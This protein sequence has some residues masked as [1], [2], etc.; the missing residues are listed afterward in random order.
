MCTDAPK[1]ACRTHPCTA[2]DSPKYAA[3][4]DIRHRT[5]A[6]SCASGGR[7][8]FRLSESPAN[9]P[10]QPTRRILETLTIDYISDLACSSRSQPS[11]RGPNVLGKQ[12]FSSSRCVREWVGW[13][14]A[15]N[16]GRQIVLEQFLTDHEL[17]FSGYYDALWCCTSHLSRDRGC[18]YHNST[19]AGKPC[20]RCLITP[21]RLQRLSFP[22]SSVFALLSRWSVRDVALCS[23][24]WQHASEKYIRAPRVQLGDRQKIEYEQQGGFDCVSRVYR[25]N[26]INS[27]SASCCCRWHDGRADNCR[28]LISAIRTANLSVVNGIR[29]ERIERY[30]MLTV[31][32]IAATALLLLAGQPWIDGLHAVVTFHHGSPVQIT[33]AHDSP[34]PTESSRKA[35]GWIS[36]DGSSTLPVWFCSPVI[37][38]CLNV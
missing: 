4:M 17:L 30:R 38:E 34:R 18:G 12:V 33:S 15:P 2:L 14:L 21:Q 23:P 25:I 1:A 3:C 31:L 6:K 22:L 28:T 37:H 27:R 32:L 8:E 19:A 24:S 36:E 35:G 10:A 7:G 16:S 29:W 20:R 13:Q 11:S 26:V 9:Q 5:L